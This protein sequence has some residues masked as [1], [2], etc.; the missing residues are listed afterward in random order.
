MNGY[1]YVQMHIQGIELSHYTRSSLESVRVHVARLMFVEPKQVYIAG[2]ELS[3]SLL[4]TIMVPEKFAGYLRK[5]TEQ[6][7]CIKEWTSLAVNYILIDGRT[8]NL[9]TG[10]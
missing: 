1:K 7:A 8:Y 9:N 6:P 4:I 10:I 2:I 5:A 3:S